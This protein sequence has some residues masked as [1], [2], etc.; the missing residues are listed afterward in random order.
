MERS[1]STSSGRKARRTPARAIEC[2]GTAAG[3]TAPPA[4]RSYKDGMRMAEPWLPFHESRMKGE[5]IGARFRELHLYHG[6][7]CNRACDFC[8]V[9]GRTDGWNEPFTPPVLDRALALV[10]PNGNLE[11]YG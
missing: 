3:Q 5:K 8:T 4:W 6:S 10:D 11:L 1:H 2:A 9:S 7:K